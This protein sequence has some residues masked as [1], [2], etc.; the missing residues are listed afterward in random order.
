[1]LRLLVG[2]LLGPTPG[3]GWGAAS[4]SRLG[5]NWLPA[6][7]AAAAGVDAVLALGLLLQRAS[8]EVGP[9]QQVHHDTAA[10]IR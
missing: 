2:L 5:C 9:L 3:L 4:C 8:A 10:Y 6:A 7:A 1:M